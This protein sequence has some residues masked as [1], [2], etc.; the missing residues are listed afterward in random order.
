M[1][2]TLDIKSGA[3]VAATLLQ[4]G[5]YWELERNGINE[6]F[7]FD[8]ENHL[9]FYQ[10]KPVP[11]TTHILKT[12]GLYPDY[13]FV[14]PYYLT[15]GS[16][17]HLGTEY[18]DKGTLDESSLDPEISPYVEQ[19]ALVKPYFPF[20]IVGI[21]VKKVHPRLLYAGI[22]DRVITGNTNYVLYLTKDRYKLEAVQNIRNHFN[23][24]QSALNVYQWK[25]ENMKE[26]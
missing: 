6:D 21:E 22:I 19:Y 10:D 20:D 16:Y 1:S 12:M 5:S 3:K 23:I 2:S 18:F 13:S 4:I 17:I 26:E 15:R 7:I 9:F 25:K 24:F 11:S 8:E 14:D